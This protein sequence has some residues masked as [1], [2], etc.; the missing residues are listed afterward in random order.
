MPAK[1]GDLIRHFTMSKRKASDAQMEIQQ[2]QRDRDEN[3]K[4]KWV[5]C[6]PPRARASA[7]LE[8]LVGSF[9]QKENNALMA[10]NRMLRNQIAALSLSNVHLQHTLERRERSVA[11]FRVANR[12]LS[13]VLQTKRHEVN[14]LRGQ[15]EDMFARFPEVGHEYNWLNAEEVLADDEEEEDILLDRE[16]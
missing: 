3:F 7:V 4:S 8:S 1:P 5:N 11:R 2:E 13:E 6:R 16:L 9:V 15:I 10:E 14:F 12:T